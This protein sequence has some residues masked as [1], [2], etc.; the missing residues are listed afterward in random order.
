M[1]A[2]VP[3]L[4]ANLANMYQQSGC[5]KNLKILVQLLLIECYIKPTAI[6][7]GYGGLV[8]VV[9][10]NYFGVLYLYFLIGEKQ[11]ILKLFSKIKYT[12]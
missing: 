11:I 1:D 6:R 2:T 4:E 8:T 9:D 5:S 10:V 12:T 7:W 3:I